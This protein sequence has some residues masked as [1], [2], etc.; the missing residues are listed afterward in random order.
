MKEY[1]P[2]FKRNPEVIYL[3]SAATTLRPANYKQHRDLTVH[4]SCYPDSTVAFE[5]VRSSVNTFLRSFEKDTIFTSGAT[6]SMNVI[7]RGLKYQYGDNVVL[8]GLEHNSSYAPWLRCPYLDVR[9]TPLTAE[10][11][12]NVKLLF[13]NVDENTRA[14]IVTSVCNVTGTEAPLSEI[15]EQSSDIPVI[16][17]A[18]QSIAH[19]IP[20]HYDL[21]IFSA[22]KMYGPTGVG[23]IHGDLSNFEPLKAGSSAVREIRNGQLIWSE[24]PHESGT[25]NIDGVLDFANTL[26]FVSFL[27]SVVFLPY[28]IAGLR[29]IPRVEIYPKH[30]VGLVSFN[31][32]GY[33]AYDVAEDLV[34]NNIYVRAGRHCAD[35]VFESLPCEETVRVSLGVY[36]NVQDIDYFIAVMRKLYR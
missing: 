4:R 22:H 11:E 3:D 14:I 2:F 35:L 13:E 31:V 29:T 26:Y 18:S 24:T 30:E 19:S 17:D 16:L 5:A 10:G 8:S 23:V 6:E 27:P 1:F 20:Q 32:A 7:A 25:P 9:T 34:K 21:C 36:N 33:N 12:V 28:L 15:Y